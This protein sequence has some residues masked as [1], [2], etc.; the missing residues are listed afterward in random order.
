[1]T[2]E[3]DRRF[4]L[5]IFQFVDEHVLSVLVYVLDHRLGLLQLLEFVATFRKEQIRNLKVIVR[6]AVAES[7]RRFPILKFDSA[8]KLHI[9]PV[10]D[11]YNALLALL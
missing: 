2:Q 11:L 1:M 6:D 3:L 4:W 8:Q 7:S 10:R 9:H 5:Y